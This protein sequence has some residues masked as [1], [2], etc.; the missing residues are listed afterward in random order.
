V[1]KSL[2]KDEPAGHEIASY[3]KD[4]SKGR[5]YQ[6]MRLKWVSILP[7]KMMLKEEI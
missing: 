6:V 1:F 7:S 4:I 3:R 5:E 2:H